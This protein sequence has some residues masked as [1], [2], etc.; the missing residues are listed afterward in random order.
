LLHST[1][2]S[3]SVLDFLLFLEETFVADLF[4]GIVCYCWGFEQHGPE[5]CCFKTAEGVHGGLQLVKESIP[6]ETSGMVYVWVASLE[7]AQKKIVELGGEV[8]IKKKPCGPGGSGS[9]FR[10]SEGN[11]L[12]LFQL[13]SPE[14]HYSDKENEKTDN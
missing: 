7:E 3:V 10:D 6:K 9:F 14:Q 1:E 8:L 12:A 13:D 11:K 5:Y 4:R 2:V